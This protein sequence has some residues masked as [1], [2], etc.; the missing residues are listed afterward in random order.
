MNQAIS[1]NQ[2]LHCAFQENVDDVK[3]LEFY[4]IIS[5]TI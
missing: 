4:N 1:K 2:G 5:G 3:T